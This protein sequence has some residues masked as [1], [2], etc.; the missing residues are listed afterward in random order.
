MKKTILLLILIL[1]Q[2]I[3]SQTKLTE[4]QKLATTCKVWGF[5]K[6]YHPNVADGR[7]NWDE[8]LFIILPQV[9]KAQTKEEFSF[10]STFGE[11]YFTFELQFFFCTLGHGYCSTIPLAKCTKKC[12]QFKYAISFSNI[13]YPFS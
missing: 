8:Q 6:Y 4:I 2:T 13:I 1:T 3:F 5:L 12:S 10:L 11:G 7:K 9:E